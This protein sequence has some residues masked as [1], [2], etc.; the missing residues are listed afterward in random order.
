M[1]RIWIV[2]LL[3]SG[4]A[5]A[6]RRGYFLDAVSDLKS[7]LQDLESPTGPPHS[8]KVLAAGA[9]ATIQSHCT[10]FGQQNRNSRSDAAAPP[11]AAADDPQN[12]FNTRLFVDS[13]RKLLFCLPTKS[14]NTMVSKVVHELVP[15]LKLQP[16]LSGLPDLHLYFKVALLRDPLSRLAATFSYK[17]EGK[18]QAGGRQPPTFEEFLLEVAASDPL[19]MDPHVQR[20]SDACLHGVIGYDFIL[21][22]ET[23][24]ENMA[25]LLRYFQEQYGKDS[26]QLDKLE[27]SFQRYAA[28]MNDSSCRYKSMPA[29]TSI[30]PNVLGNL[31]KT[32]LPDIDWAQEAEGGVTLAHFTS[33]RSVR[34]EHTWAHYAT[35]MAPAFTKRARWS[36]APSCAAIG[37]QAIQQLDTGTA[38]LALLG[39]WKTQGRWSLADDVV[40]KCPLRNRE[41]D[42][43]ANPLDLLAESCRT[44]AGGHF[45]GVCSLVGAEVAKKFDS[46]SVPL[47]TVGCILQERGHGRFV[48][49]LPLL[50][51][52]RPYER[53]KLATEFALTFQRLALDNFTISDHSAGQW[54]SDTYLTRVFL[55]DTERLVRPGDLYAG[56]DQGAPETLQGFARKPGQTSFSSDVYVLGAILTNI[57]LSAESFFPMGLVPEDFLCTGSRGKFANHSGVPHQT[58][59]TPVALPHKPSI[60][61]WLVHLLPR[62]PVRACS[63][64]RPAP[65]HSLSRSATH[66]YPYPLSPTQLPTHA[67]PRSFAHSHASYHARTLYIQCCPSCLLLRRGELLQVHGPAPPIDDAAPITQAE[68]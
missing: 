27:P 46:A 24:Q 8:G 38:R 6:S 44:A 26:V 9:S 37:V 45:Y 30:S 12:V 32:I 42:W 29:T 11:I 64:A 50:R 4:S 56:N 47:G 66:K 57:F 59:N 15:G 40:I 53:K 13:E 7:W 49:D 14:G 61:P 19:K 34:L 18:P 43:G 65:A 31:T 55:C 10:F 41:T 5:K 17:V 52:L 60:F 23:L 33:E 1:L 20:Q 68:P 36:Q 25:E 67:L 54:C 16:L 58:K 51:A 28:C 21:R 35:V 22:F 39:R 63:P 62:R 2:V 48:A 3:C